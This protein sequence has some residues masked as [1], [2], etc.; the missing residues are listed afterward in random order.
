MERGIG[1]KL[2]QS[3]NYR[4][5]LFT[6]YDSRSLK[7]KSVCDAAANVRGEKPPVEPKRIIELGKD[8]VRLFRKSPAPQIFRFAH[9]SVCVRMIVIR[10]MC[11]AETSL[12]LRANSLELCPN[13]K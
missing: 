8:L 12:R 13:Q 1:R 2:R 9:I 7:P 5:G 4:I 11:F 6:S 3:A 10:A